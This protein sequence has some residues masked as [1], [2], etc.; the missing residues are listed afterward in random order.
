MLQ[1]P[2][3]LW[4]LVLALPLLI[5]A[6][7]SWSI[8]IEP[9]LLFVHEFEL[10]PPR[11]TANI[12]GLRVA[13][14]TDIHAGGLWIDEN[15][16]KQI[17]EK[18]NS[19]H[20]DL[21]VLLGDYVHNKGHECSLPPEVFCKILGNLHAPCGVYAVLGNHDWDYGYDRTARA[22]RINGIN[23]LENAAVPLRFKGQ[24]IWL[25]GVGDLS[26]KPD[27][28]KALNTVPTDASSIV[29]THDPN[30]FPQIPSR[31]NLT[32][33]GHTHGG[34]VWL[35]LLHLFA[36]KMGCFEPYVKDLVVQSNGMLFISIGI[37]NSVFPIR[38]LNAP[39]ISILNLRVQS[40]AE[41]SN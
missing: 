32:I 16:I 18:T 35:P 4:L 39:E 37:G 41:K 26:G 38:F 19:A 29:I 6:F 12:S 21:I 36:P 10:H 14:I 25:S 40:K 27:V 34:Q 2:F 31:V 23:V 33:A 1:K 20:P 3:K 30:I 9:N 8:L 22:L 7:F 28:A 5:A 13:A 15:K 17:V 11:W 24:T